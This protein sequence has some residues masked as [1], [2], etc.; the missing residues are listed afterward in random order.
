MTATA[1]ERIPTMLLKDLLKEL[2]GWPEETRVGFSGLNFYRV[3]PRG[4]NMVNIEFNEHVYRDSKGELIA[5]DLLLRT[6]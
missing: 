2:N 3:K 1:E 4:P 6:P 5:E